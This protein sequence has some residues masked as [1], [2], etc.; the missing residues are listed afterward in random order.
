MQA[1]KK[2]L[3]LIFLI[4]P[5]WIFAQDSQEFVDWNQG[6]Q[7]VWNDYKGN[8]EP[9]SDAAATTTTYLGR[10]YS[11]SNDQFA[12]TIACRF[13]KK[14]SW[15]LYKTDHILGHEQ[16]HFDITEI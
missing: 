12:Y 13:S 16:G 1:I 2:S 11:F 15:G 3:F 7:L 4:N 14:K 8:P 10:E 5:T 9:G 6:R